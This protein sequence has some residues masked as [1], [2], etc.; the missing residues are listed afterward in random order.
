[1]SFALPEPWRSEIHPRRG[2]V[3]TRTVRPDP[4]AR[5]TVDDM[6]REIPGF[7]AGVILSSLTEPAL[8][9]AARAG[10]DTPAPT[11]PVGA[12]VIATTGI[13]VR[14]PANL[15]HPWFA[16]LWLAERGV[17]FAAE[18]AT[19]LFG[20]ELALE[21]DRRTFRSMRRDG[22]ETAG[23]RRLAPGEQ[24]MSA[25]VAGPQIEILLR[26]R[27]ALAAAPDQIHA[28]TVAALAARRGLGAYQRCATSVLAP[29][30]TGWVAQDCAE[31]LADGDGVRMTALLFA[32]GT[33][34][35]ADRLA[36]GT[37]RIFY[38]RRD[39]GATLVD[40]VGPDGAAGPLLRW[41]DGIPAKDSAGGRG[42]LSL[43]SHLPAEEA[44]QGLIDRV[45]QPHVRP[46]L[47]DM[48]RLFPERALRLLALTPVRA[49]VGDLLR[50]LVLADPGLAAT[51]AA[52]LAEAPAGRIRDAVAAG[53]AA[54]AAP[55]EAL[56]PL[57]TAPPWRDRGRVKPVRLSVEIARPAE[58]VEWRPGERE[59]FLASPFHRLGAG[60]AALPALLER[61]KQAP[62]AVIGLLQPFEAPVLPWLMNYWF[63]HRPEH[64]AGAWAWLDRHPHAAAGDLVPRSLGSSHADRRRAELGVR[65]LVA[66]GHG[67]TVRGVARSHGPE[68][69]AALE[70]MLA[71]DP[72]QWLPAKLPSVPAWVEPALLPPVRLRDGSGVLPAGVLTDLA[73]VL[74]L[75]VT[76]H[77][78]GLA[79]T[80]EMLEP[81]DLAEFGW[82]LF[83]LWQANGADAK[84]VWVLEALGLIG[85]D[86]TVRRLTPRILSW[87]GESGHARAVTGLEI[88]A[89]LGTEVALL[90]LS[91]IAQRSR[92]KG[93]KAAAEQTMTRVA[94]RLGLSSE[95]L[96]DRVIPDF[97]LAADGSMVLDYGPRRFT[98]GFDE[99][100]TPY[101]RD[102][103]GKRLRAL[104]KPGVRDD[105]SLAPGTFQRYAALKK[106]VRTVAADQVS[107]L[108]RAMVAG[109]RW[110]VADFQRFLVCHPLLGHVAKRLV[111][112]VYDGDGALAG[113]V[114]VA[115]DR[116]LA[117]VHDEEAEPAAGT[118]MG[119]AH[120]LHLG[121][122]VPGWA[123]VFADYR[124]VQPFAQLAREVF[125]LGADEA[126]GAELVRFRGRTVPTGRVL[127]LE[128]RG[129]RRA[130]AMDGG[131]QGE[132]QV[133]VGD[134]RVFSLAL[135]P[136]IAV[137]A[138]DLFPE[139]TLGSA[140]LGGVVLGRLDPVTASEILR[141][142]TTLTA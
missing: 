115:E 35:Q 10:G 104:P 142:L 105:P 20:M 4:Q 125:E 70:T 141:D 140:G 108:E 2:G 24:I 11:D 98:V 116:T 80:A 53:V 127:G 57:L 122:A 45:N 130:S 61:A 87:P 139:Q 82:A 79:P 106:D 12:A 65:A 74:A 30:E 60:V 133:P 135:S 33:A 44:M 18:A 48:A 66:G 132:I 14:F 47:L 51:V 22:T 36:A 29:T 49:G 92:Y 96:A 7:V 28:E 50:A 128:R 38:Q 91:A 15:K 129:W 8:S 31:A 124:I 94:A 117:D 1:M 131:V 120:P 16:D 90:H 13:A 62:A 64:R 32:A 113:A 43:L 54:A 71:T 39:L 25:Y 72:L 78:P 109:R 121:A 75:G 26:V 93:L 88:L 81:A 86:E 102:A 97:G 110:S 21:P 59:N 77:Y 136:G 76:D 103:A 99:H 58:S 37:S 112:G 40:G 119:V 23:V 5:A 55:A 101:V 73:M 9:A 134:G 56:P 27:A 114:R 137:G 67:D 17:R 126:A 111:W 85:D 68:A 83:T 118:T 95:E 34:E 41:L 52:G 89:Q 46:A 42:L 107:R 63:V 138:V 100:L 6:L 19:E 84:Q 3:L 69:A 123:E